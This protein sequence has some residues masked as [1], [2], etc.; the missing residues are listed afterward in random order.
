MI[1]PILASLLVSVGPASLAGQVAPVIDTHWHA[2]LSPGDL[3]SEEAVTSRAEAMERLDSLNVERIVV[4]G[5]PDAIEVWRAEFPDR[6]IPALLFPCRDGLAPN[7]G[8]QCFPDGRVFPDTAWLRTEIEEGRVHALGEITT[9]YLGI[10]PAD[11]RMAPYYALAEELDIPVMIHLGLGPPAAA[12]P[13]SP[14]PYGSP[15]FRAT[16]GRPLGL[17]EVLLQHKTLRVLIMHAGWPLIDE[18]IYM[19]HQHPQ[20]YVDIAVLQWAIPRQAYLS[21]LRRLVDA[22]YADRILIGSDT[23][24]GRLVEAIDALREADFLTDAQ[25]RAILYDNAARFFR[26]DGGSNGGRGR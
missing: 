24:M 17:E 25:R 6:V 16:A 19:L 26:L 3:H 8:R 22:G 5:V 1:L 2:R 14:A 12:Y 10:P 7:F 4:N 21:T 18:T 15:D 11:E 9:Q 13:S 23:G 20:V